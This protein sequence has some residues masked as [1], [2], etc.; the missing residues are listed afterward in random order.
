MQESSAAQKR[1]IS[2][3]LVDDVWVKFILEY[4]GLQEIGRLAQVDKKF[5]SLTRNNS[6]WKTKYELH[7]PHRLEKVSASTNWY[8]E[9]LKATAEEYKGLPLEVQRLMFKAKEGKTQYCHLK[10]SNDLDNL[11]NAKDSTKTTPIEWL[12]WL[13]HQ[14]MLDSIF[15]FA[16]GEL[17]VQRKTPAKDPL[18]KTNEGWG[19]AHWAVV[20][21][22]AEHVLSQHLGTQDFST[23]PTTPFHVAAQFGL[24][25]TLEFLLPKFQVDHRT[26]QS[27]KYYAKKNRTALHLAAGKGH[28]DCVTYLVE[29]NADCSA[30]VHRTF[31]NQVWDNWTT[32]LH[33]AAQENHAEVAEFLVKKISPT[34]YQS[35]LE[36]PL[37]Y[38][39]LNNNQNLFDLFIQEA[40]SAQH[41]NTTPNEQKAL[42]LLLQEAV[43]SGNQHFIKPVLELGAN[44]YWKDIWKNRSA[45]DMVYDRQDSESM[46]ILV[47]DTPLGQINYEPP[48]PSVKYFFI[49]RGIATVLMIGIIVLYATLFDSD[50]DLRRLAVIFGAIALA[51]VIMI[52]GWL[53]VERLKKNSRKEE[54]LEFMRRAI[55]DTNGV[56]E[57]IQSTDSNGGTYHALPQE[58]TTFSKQYDSFGLL[59]K[60]EKDLEKGDY[61]DLPADDYEMK[62]IK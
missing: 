14:P 29:N 19:S 26:M 40:K 59:G 62:R 36:T 27:S 5:L 3:K 46:A 2:I 49:P 6:F 15:K 4:F 22:Q 53:L 43:A 44:P 12:L 23:F 28:L 56:R 42:D 33:Y 61:D 45:I 31:E 7:F 58:L 48:V 25:K 1:A 37:T 50:S 17:Q 13:N 35:K 52:G 20:C 10:N 39:I 47:G 34:K 54:T 57:E 38:T 30:T 21:N 51:A 32:A 60:S 16:L 24:V 18:K 55:E 8:E 41:T 11:L 9:F